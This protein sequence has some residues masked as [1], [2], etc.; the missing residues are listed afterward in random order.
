M[1]HVNEQDVNA[2]ATLKIPFDNR[3][4]VLILLAYESAGE[5]EM[6]AGCESLSDDDIEHVDEDADG[7][8]VAST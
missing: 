3:M 2:E 5:F 8:M 6:S 4:S 1:I 7:S